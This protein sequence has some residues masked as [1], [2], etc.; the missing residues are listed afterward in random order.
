LPRLAIANACPI[1]DQQEQ[2][3]KAQE[4]EEGEKE[5]IRD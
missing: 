3:E 2:A 4:E 5:G 1:R